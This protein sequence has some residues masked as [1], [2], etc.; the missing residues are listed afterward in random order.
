[1]KVGIFLVLFGRRPLAEALDFVKSVG[2]ESVEIGTGGYV[3]NAHCKPHELLQDRVELE[4]FRAA[5]RTRDLEISALSCHGNPLHP[6]P[7]VAQAHDADFRNSVR[8]AAELASGA[9]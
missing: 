8:L 4:K 1:M 3:G 6:D 7:Q 9:S 5:I 2:C